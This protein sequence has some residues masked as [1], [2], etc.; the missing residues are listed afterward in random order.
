MC[1]YLRETHVE[2]CTAAAVRKLLQVN[3]C[4]TCGSTAHE[5]CGLFR[6]Q[7]SDGDTCPHWQNTLAQYC[8][9]APFTRYIPGN[10]GASR[11]RAAGHRYCEMYAES[12][13]APEAVPSWLL[14]SANHMWVDVGDD[15]SWHMGVDRMLAEMLVAVE[16]VD[17]LTTYGRTYPA[18]TLRVSGVDWQMAFPEPLY[19]TGHNRHVRNDPSRIVKHPY[20][21]G[22]LL[23]G[24]RGEGLRDSGLL[25]SGAAA[26][27]WMTDECTRI[28]KRSGAIK[29]EELL[30]VLHSFFSPYQERSA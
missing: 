14:F 3:G 20:T 8:S 25:L 17:Y 1:P 21:F 7:P 28:P 15:G 9:R 10:Q 2:Y 19:I 27:E 29:R 12:Q 6:L 30:G 5:A 26:R 22:W 23:E 11:C 24:E 16:R 4:S 18:V 13:T